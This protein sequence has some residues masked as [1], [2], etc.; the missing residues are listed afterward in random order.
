MMVEKLLLAG[1]IAVSSVSAHADIYSFSY[2]RGDTSVISGTL[3]GMLQADNN[4]VVVTSLVGAPQLNGL[5]GPSLLTIASTDTANFGTAG[6]QPRVSL[7][8]SFMDIIACDFASPVNCNGRGNAITFNAGNATAA[9]FGGGA[10]FAAYD[11]FFG[12]FGEQ[13][14]AARWSLT[15]VPEPGIWVLLV[16]GILLLRAHVARFAGVTNPGAG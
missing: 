3:N 2:T 12:E 11:G 4:T 15:P 9:A 6:L 16:C 8:G 7:N 1:L 5:A 14:L 10:P 13:F